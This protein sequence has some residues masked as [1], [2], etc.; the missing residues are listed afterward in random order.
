MAVLSDEFE[1]VSVLTVFEVRKYSPSN[2]LD[3]VLDSLP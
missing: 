3:R 2:P 1:L